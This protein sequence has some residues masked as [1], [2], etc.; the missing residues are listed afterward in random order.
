MTTNNQDLLQKEYKKRFKKNEIYRK[1]MWRILV[2][3]YFSN[4]TGTNNTVLDLGAGW[5]EFINNV[6][7]SK[8]H[9]ID[10]NPEVLDR[11][12]DDVTVLNQD[13]S[14]KW[15]LP[16]ESID[17]IFSSNFLEHLPS[18]DAVEKTLQEAARCLKK[19][20]KCI[21]LGPNIKYTGGAY[22]DFWDHR[23]PITDKSIAE[24]LELSGFVVTTSIDR[25]LPYTMSGGV[26]PPVF[27]VKL[28]L[29]LPFMWRFFGKQF[30][31]IAERQ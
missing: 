21:L 7:A 19:G 2:N 15:D 29:K 9:A 11:A 3:D 20:G 26:N 23:V 18:H 22:W 30:L 24:I 1:R 14:M 10:L 31:V 13:C 8:K 28:Y 17:V 6:Q 25:F 5:C 27:F 4:H 12:N 16:A